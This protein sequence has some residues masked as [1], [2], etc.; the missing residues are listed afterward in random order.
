MAEIARPASAGAWNRRMAF[1]KRVI[2]GLLYYLLLAS[3]TLTFMMPLVWMITS[4][5]KPEGYVFE[6]PPRLIAERIQWWNYRDAWVQFPFWTGL[7]NTMTI[8]MGVLVGRLM[9]AG[10]T[11]F[12]FA[13]LRFRGRNF[14]FMLVLSTM[15][16]PQQVR[17]IPQFL[18]FR[19]FGWLNSMKPLIWPSW[20]GGGAYFIFLLR[21]FFMTI[22]RDYDDA[23]RIDG[24]GSFGILW[25][26]IA[27]MSAP[28][29]GVV[30]I[31]T[32]M[33]GWNAFFGPTIYLNTIDKYTLSVAIRQWQ[34]L[35]DLSAGANKPG[36]VHIMA[37]STVLTVPPVV[38]Y[39]FT[40][41][42]FVQGVVISGVKG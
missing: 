9:S 3:L 21:Q 8:I 6:Y 35:G 34:W 37:M 36:W 12:A 26:I 32:F 27:P 41:R 22:P 1:S 33:G 19:W 5:F 20:F 42:Y 15:M 18:L 7:K 10:L 4:S 2:Y 40:Q 13:R 14:L 31:F 17:L 39:F 38:V 24:C 25:R 23:A 30:A 16:I 29:L 11:A 28:V